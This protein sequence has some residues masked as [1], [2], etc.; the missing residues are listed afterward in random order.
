MPGIR[1][2]SYDEATETIVL[3]GCDMRAQRQLTLEAARCTSRSG[4]SVMATSTPAHK[5]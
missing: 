3:Y 4:K 2:E 5:C 1:L